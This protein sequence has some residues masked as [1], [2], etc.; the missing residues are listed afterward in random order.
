MVVAR[1]THLHVLLVVLAV[2]YHSRAYNQQYPILQ[3]IA[4]TLIS[5]EHW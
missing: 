3:M 1:L 4:Q 5:F 2:R